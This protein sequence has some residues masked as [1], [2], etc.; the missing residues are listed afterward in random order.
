MDS[1]GKSPE[2]SYGRPGQLNG[3]V[4]HQNPHRERR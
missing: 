3:E 1:S 2:V 4:G